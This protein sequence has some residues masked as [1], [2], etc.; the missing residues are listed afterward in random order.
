MLILSDAKMKTEPTLRAR[1]QSAATRTLAREELRRRILEIVNQREK[2]SDLQLWHASKPDYLPWDFMIAEIKALHA[3]GKLRLEILS[4]GEWL[5]H[6]LETTKPK[7]KAEKKV[8]RPKRIQPEP[9]NNAAG[10]EIKPAGRRT[11]RKTGDDQR[12]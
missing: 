6:S 8:T 11:R 3:D 7:A 5:I 1:L 4:P 9:I 12:H 2:I 10:A